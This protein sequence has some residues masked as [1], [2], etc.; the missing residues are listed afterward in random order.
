LK[1]LY[2]LFVD[3]NHDIQGNLDLKAEHSDNFG[4]SL[5]WVRTR[6][7]RTWRA[8]LGGFYNGI[9]DL[10][11]LAQ[12][13]GTRYSYVNI[14]RYRTTGGNAGVSWSNDKWTVSVGANLTGRSDDLAQQQAEQ[15]LWSNEARGSV[16]YAWAKPRL[17][18]QAFYKRQGELANYTSLADG[19]VGRG[20]INAYNMADASVT[21]ALWGPRLRVTAG[22]KNLFD[23]QNVGTSLGAGDGAHASGG[24][25]VPMM[26]GRI[27]FLRLD[28]ELIGK[29]R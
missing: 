22:A 14:G 20:T 29:E 21:K 28:L 8:E 10:I 1:E 2:F 25:S 4:A 11:T 9:H 18:F 19:T 5:T 12:V 6:N 15:Y 3:V 17:S 13:N 26:T 24:T 27:W 7:T 23:V 16:S